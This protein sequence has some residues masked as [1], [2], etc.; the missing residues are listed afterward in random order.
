MTAATV[1][2]IADTAAAA[3]MTAPMAICDS[4]LPKL[5]LT[6]DIRQS[7]QAHTGWWKALAYGR[8]AGHPVTIG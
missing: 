1:L 6:M 8:A 7:D 2:T 5:P 4:S 3:V